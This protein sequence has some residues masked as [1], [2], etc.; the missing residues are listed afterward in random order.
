V[1]DVAAGQVHAQVGPLQLDIEP[2]LT[3]HSRSPDGF[4]TIF[5]KQRVD[6]LTR[7]SARQSGPLL[8]IEYTAARRLRV[9]A[10]TLRIHA[11]RDLH[12][13]VYSHLNSFTTIRVR[14]H[15]HLGLAF[16]PCPAAIIDVTHSDYPVGAPARFAYLDAHGMFRVAQASSA[17]KGPFTILASGTLSRGEPL[18]VR[19]IELAATPPRTLAE[20]RVA[21]WSRQLSTELSPTA[22]F[23]VPEN[24]IEF[25]LETRDPNSPAYVMLS[26]ADT[27]I[28]RGWD[29]VAH[30]P[31]HY[32][33]HLTLTPASSA[34]RD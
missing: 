13:I 31:G 14:G 25:G 7:R 3:F 6:P 19:L 33:N 30:R 21:D 15:H 26:L 24:S 9:D 23:D 12:E 11:S 16:S 2:L 17:E 1:V 8:D 20:L 28:G 32:E 34:P 29:T 5:S 22:G 4:W 27:S 18:G 10:S